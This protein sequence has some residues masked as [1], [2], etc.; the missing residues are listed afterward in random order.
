MQGHSYSRGQPVIFQCTE[1]ET[2]W[3]HI[4]LELIFMYCFKGRGKV[5]LYSNYDYIFL[6]IREHCI[7]IGEVKGKLFIQAELLY[8]T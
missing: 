3:R 6:D 8:L 1:C 5:Y 7:S 2:G 4:S